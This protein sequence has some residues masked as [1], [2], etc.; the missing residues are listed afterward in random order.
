MLLG[1]LWHGANW[2]FIVWGALHGVYLMI[3]H[4]WLAVAAR[5]PALTAFRHSRSGA[6]FGLILTFLAV[7][8]AWV[9]FRAHSF[10]GA[11]NLLAGMAGLHGVAIPSGLAFAVA[12]VRGLLNVLGIRFA[13]T[14]GTV[15]LMTYGWVMALLADC[16]SVPEQPADPG[17]VRSGAGG[18]G[19]PGGRRCPGSGRSG[20][21]VGMAAFRLMGI[22]HRLRG[23]HRHD[24]DHAGQRISL[25]AVLRRCAP[26]PIC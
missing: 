8:V 19:P 17:A 16:V 15:L 24:L 25:L 14:S 7:V 11:F 2:T 3:N 1:G 20:F 5:S 26:P 6:A 10:S 22:C 12:P 21:V 18:L 4:A 9:F 23:I 13:D